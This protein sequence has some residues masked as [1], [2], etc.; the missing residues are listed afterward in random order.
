MWRTLSVCCALYYQDILFMATILMTFWQMIF[1]LCLFGLFIP[2]DIYVPNGFKCIHYCVYV[3]VY[4]TA[5]V[6]YFGIIKEHGTILIYVY[7]TF[8]NPKRYITIKS[9]WNCT[10]FCKQAGHYKHKISFSNNIQSFRKFS[11]SATKIEV[12][13]TNW[14]TLGHPCLKGSLRMWECDNSISTESKISTEISRTNY[15]WNERTKSNFKQL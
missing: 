5:I 6:I 2:L 9:I 11:K 10:H 15:K 12:K 1:R 14:P 4:L 13:D 8:S 7:I 3:F